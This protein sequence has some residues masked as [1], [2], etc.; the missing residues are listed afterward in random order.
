MHI[1]KL[2]SITF[3]KLLIC[4]IIMVIKEE[5]N[6]IDDLHNIIKII[7]KINNKN[8]G[9]VLKIYICKSFYYFTNN[10]FEE[11]KKFVVK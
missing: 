4:Q 1:W 3:V 11:L 9:K 2:Y 7:E 10:N 8:V 5:S 6:E